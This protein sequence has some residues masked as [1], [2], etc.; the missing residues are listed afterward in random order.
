M[1]VVERDTS[2]TPPPPSSTFLPPSLA[3]SQ[4]FL[5]LP[6]SISSLLALFFLVNKWELLLLHSPL[7]YLFPFT[8]EWGGWNMQWRDFL[9]PGP[10]S[11]CQGEAAVAATHAPELSGTMLLGWGNEKALLSA[12]G[13]KRK[14]II[15]T[16]GATQLG[17]VQRDGEQGGGLVKRLRES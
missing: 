5:L 6:F 13:I 3:P 2:P 15:R 17:K 1:A 14:G 7:T 4:Q 16:P 10:L 8:L 12:W 9:T 11:M